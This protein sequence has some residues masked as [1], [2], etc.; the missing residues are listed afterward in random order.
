[1]KI[2]TFPSKHLYQQLLTLIML[3][4]LALAAQ[5]SKII[6]KEYGGASYAGI[7]KGEALKTWWIAGP[8]VMDSAK[9]RGMEEQEKLFDEDLLTTVKTAAGKLPPAFKI[10]GKSY[11]WRRYTSKNSI[12]NLD[13]IFKRADYA[14]AYALAEIIADSSYNALL[15]VGS[16]DGVKLW[17]N[18]KQIHRNFV[19]RGV[20]PDNDIV[21]VSLIKG[22]NQLL[23]KVH[24]M[25]GGWGFTV[26]FLD[27]DAVTKKLVSAA[28]RGDMEEL[29]MLLNAGAMLNEKD[30][31]GLTAVGAA[32]LHGRDE[33]VKLL[34]QKGA[35]DSPLP[36]PDVMID[37]LY[38]SLNGKPYP[39]IAVLVAKDG[40]VVYKKGFGYADIETKELVTANTKFRIG[41]ITKQFTASAILKLQEA[42]KLQLTDKLSKFIPDFPRGDEVTIH[43]L[44]THTSGIHS[45]T[46]KEGFFDKVTSPVKSD[47]VVN[48]IKKD[49]FDFSPGEQWKYNNSGYFLLSFI[50]EK[51]TGKSY[52]EYLKETFFDPLQMA[53]TGVHASTLKLTNEAKGYTKENE[54]YVR[55]LNWDMSW[56]GGAGNLYSTVEDLYK[57]N[58]AVFGGK[59][60]TDKNLKAAF[61]SVILNNGK[62][63][64]GGQYGYGWAIGK[65]RGLDMIQHSGGLHGFLTQLS[66]YPAEHLTVVML[67][68]VVPS[69]VEINPGTIAEF[70]LA[71]KMEKQPSYMAQSTLPQDVKQYEGRYDFGNGAVMTITS[72]DKNLFA[73]LSGQGKF[74][75]FPSSPGE[76]FWKVVE[77]R[78]KFIKNEKGEITGGQFFQNGGEV[79]VPKLK[80]EIFVTVDSSIYKE[81]A[82]NYDYGNNMIIYITTENGKLF[83]M[84][85]GEPKFELFP[86]SDTIFLIKELN[87]RII[88]YRGDGGTVTKLNVDMPG[89]KRDAPRMK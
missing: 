13:S 78:I 25:Q 70:Y 61:T 6:S 23:V 8:V 24:N 60:I 88:F 51:I 30:A 71:G 29:N 26:R 58:E 66:R 44:L 76:F 40:K 11:N 21:P 83:G 43:H 7:N 49:S 75:I 47:D 57:W 73:Q 48:S 87:A 17:L 69:Q 67:T 5:Q 27:K 36:E 14:E 3:L 72:D 38:A 77:A 79:K 74:P 33:I 20:V 54:K 39:G 4:P 1:M 18:G 22:S 52:G 65:N 50:I 41:S 80:D 68:N 35:A 34:R 85:T 31:S 82:G 56:A 84:A 32:K 15:G 2:F 45:F 46:D 55:A 37:G 86:L 16:D 81:Y 12:I 9:G 42:G 63:P 89:E 53:N 19:G 59:V 10:K 64:D 62:T 28:G